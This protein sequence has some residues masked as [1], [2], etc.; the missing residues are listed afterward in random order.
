MQRYLEGFFFFF[1]VCF[2][3]FGFIS[4]RYGWSKPTCLLDI[5]MVLRFVLICIV[6]LHPFHLLC[7]R[8]L[9]SVA[10]VISVKLMNIFMGK[11]VPVVANYA[12]FGVSACLLA[13]FTQDEV[14]DYSS[15]I[16]NLL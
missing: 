10:L 3:L 11:K 13:F 6:K 5:Y 2:I 7:T 4:L 8:T 12:F 14:E 1:L 16:L 9:L 15:E